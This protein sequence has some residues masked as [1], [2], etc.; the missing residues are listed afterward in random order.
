M[1]DDGLG[2]KSDDIVLGGFDAVV[3][4]LRIL[5]FIE[6]YSSACGL[7]SVKAATH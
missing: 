1:Q 3:R 5:I 7:C 4:I 6:V 2:Q